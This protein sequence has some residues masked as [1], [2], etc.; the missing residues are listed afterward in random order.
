MAAPTY[1]DFLIDIV[2]KP[3]QSQNEWVHFIMGDYK[4]GGGLAQQIVVKYW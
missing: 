3:P 4:G 1:E 2:K